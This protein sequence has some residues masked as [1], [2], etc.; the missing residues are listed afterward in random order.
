MQGSSE[1]NQYILGQH[2]TIGNSRNNGD[3]H[4]AF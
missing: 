1:R 4:K 3:Y 2:S